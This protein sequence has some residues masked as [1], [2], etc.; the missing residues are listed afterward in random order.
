MPL[1][2]EMTMKK[3]II[4]IISGFSGAGK[5]TV[6]KEVFKMVDNLGFSVSATSRKPREGEI[7]GQHYL[8]MTK[9]EFE[10]A[11]DRGEF[12]EHA[13][14]F[15]NYYGTLKSEIEKNISAGKDMVFDINFVGAEN[16]KK[17]YPDA[18]TVFIAPPSMSVLK[19]RLIGRGSETEES[20]ARRLVEAETEAKKIAEYDYILINDKVD[21]CALN[22]VSIIKAERTK[23][24]RNLEFVNKLLEEI[25]K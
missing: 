4:F 18:V 8:F 9:E 22:L 24:I 17:T 16:L 15:G 1:K 25:E 6:L 2:A 10:G 21:E 20:L 23:R 3:G 14:T 19:D 12:A 11:I 5:G 13:L 7:H